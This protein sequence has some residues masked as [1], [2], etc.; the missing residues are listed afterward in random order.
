[1][2]RVVGKGGV[3]G[4]GRCSEEGGLGERG[5][6]GVRRRRRVEVRG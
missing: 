3:R 6:D 1:M 4:W 2:A 5:E